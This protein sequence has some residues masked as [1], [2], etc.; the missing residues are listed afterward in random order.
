[1]CAP[2]IRITHGAVRAPTNA[3]SVQGGE[4]KKSQAR[5][6]RS[7]PSTRSLHSPATGTAAAGTC[8]ITL[9]TTG[10]RSLTAT[11]AGDSNFNG[12]NSAAEPH[13]VN[14]PN[15]PPIATVTNGLCSTTS[16]AAGTLILTLADPDNDP[17]TLT[18]ASNSNTSLVPNAAIVLGGKQT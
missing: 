18:L 13:T 8:S 14:P 4:W 16:A 15:S 1:V 10:S 9:S 3:C 2:T 7:W 6:S 12:S 17:L 11:Y 5:R